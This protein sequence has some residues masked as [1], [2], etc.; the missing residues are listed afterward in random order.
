MTADG[1]GV[2]SHA[3]SELLRELASE[4][5]LATDAGTHNL[6]TKP[7]PGQP[8][9]PG[10]HEPSRTTAGPSRPNSHGHGLTVKEAG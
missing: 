3:G 8:R 6:R 5:G 7:Q 10:S 4:T 2:V 9:P 1:Q